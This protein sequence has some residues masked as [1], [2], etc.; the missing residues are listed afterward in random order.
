MENIR[1][2]VV[3]DDGEDRLILLND[4]AQTYVWEK[5]PGVGAS[6]IPHGRII[7]RH[8]VLLVVSERGLDVVSLPELLTQEQVAEIIGLIMDA[9]LSINAP[10]SVHDLS[11]I[12]GLAPI[13]PP[14][15]Q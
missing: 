7:D 8:G 11:L 9:S 2:K 6:N 4:A 1:T 13:E 10:I 14:M 12:T 3:W 15:M 5:S